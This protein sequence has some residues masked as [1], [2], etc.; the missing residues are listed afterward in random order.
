VQRC[1]VEQKGTILRPMLG[2]KVRRF[3]I[4]EVHPDDDPT[5]RGDDRH[6]P[7]VVMP[8]QN[9]VTISARGQSSGCD[10]ERDFAAGGA[11]QTYQLLCGE[12]LQT[13]VPQVRQTRRIQADGVQ[14]LCRRPAPQRIEQS[15]REL[16][17]EIGNRI[18]PRHI[19]IFYYA[20]SNAGPIERS[21]ERVAAGVLKA[22]RRQNCQAIFLGSSAIGCRKDTCCHEWH[23]S[24]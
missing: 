17:F 10:G 2:V 19:S 18:R 15:G 9:S 4:D 16:A 1:P 13:A 14:R 22:S 6:A 3:V 23:R 20:L 11:Q 7:I 12:T 8:T 21:Q 24:P 5:K